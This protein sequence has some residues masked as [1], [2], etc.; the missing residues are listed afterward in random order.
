MFLE[1][2]SLTNFRNYEKIDIKNFS[3]INFFYGLNAQGKTNLLEAIHLLCSG[4]SFREVTNRELI[5]H[6]KEYFL[7][8]GQILLDSGIKDRIVLYYLENGKK[9]LSINKKKITRFSNYFGRYPV[10]LMYPELYKVISGGPSERRKFIDFLLSETDA[11]YL[12]TLKEYTKI[13]KQR[14]FLLHQ[15]SEGK[16]VKEETLEPW[17]EKLIVNGS[18]LVKDRLNFLKKFV[19]ELSDTFNKIANK[20]LNLSINFESNILNGKS[21]ENIEY[22]FKEKLQRLKEREKRFGTTILGPHRDDFVFLVD[23]FDLK[24]FG[25]RGEYKSLLIALKIAEFNYVKEKSKEHP[26][27][28]FDDFYSELDDFRTIRIFSSMTQLNQIFLTSPKKLDITEELKK[29]GFSKEEISIYKVEDNNI[30]K[31]L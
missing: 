22:L 25:S 24:K 12:A 23:G 15:I 9:E 30:V 11:N 28:L 21:I 26:V 18:R 16:L 5:N 17:S 29:Y 2:L 1:S 20:N 13:L 14:N 4:K 7:I 10:V 3:R 27:F 6:K 8:Q 31:E 19:V